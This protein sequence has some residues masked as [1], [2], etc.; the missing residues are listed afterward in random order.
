MIFV[1]IYFNRFVINDRIIIGLLNGKYTEPLM[2]HV[3]E[4]WNELCIYKIHRKSML[5][6]LYNLAKVLYCFPEK[7]C[8]LAKY[9]HSLAKI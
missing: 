8:S 1:F 9:L 6:K 4:L 7:V 2:G 3:D 5:K